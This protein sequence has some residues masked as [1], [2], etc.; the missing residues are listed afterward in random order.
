VRELDRTAEYEANATRWGTRD[1][2][3]CARCARVVKD[4][5]IWVQFHNGG[6]YAV[7]PEEA[8]ELDVKAPGAGMG[9]WPIGADCARA[10]GADWRPYFYGPD[11]KPLWPVEERAAGWAADTFRERTERLASGDCKQSDWIDWGD[12]A[13][14]VAWSEVRSRFPGVSKDVTESRVAVHA[15]FRRAL[16]RHGLLPV[17]DRKMTAGDWA[18]RAAGKE[19]Q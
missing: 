1:G 10:L 12:P 18:A 7:T 5:A 15:L 11:F 14:R 6:W 4:P 13:T 19:G 17:L 8:T 16:A 9:F 3:G 2:A